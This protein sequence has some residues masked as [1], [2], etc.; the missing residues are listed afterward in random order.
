MEKVKI[1]II[2]LLSILLSACS[3]QVEGQD[4]IYN[5]EHVA[6]T[7]ESSLKESQKTE[8]EKT[9]QIEQ[10]LCEQVPE[11]NDYAD[12]ISSQ[13]DGAANLTIHIEDKLVEVY[14]DGIGSEYL[15]KYYAV[16]VGES[17]IDHSVRWDMF[18]V[19]ENCDKVLWKD[20]IRLEGSNF[21]MYTLEEWRSS[22]HYR[23]LK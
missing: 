9:D 14:K 19:S 12:Y 15:G 11:L 17:W 22:S 23:I 20:T 10:F 8:P 3:K 5:I 7:S 16:Y 2:I 4:S 21:D 13:S 6:E 18:Y 1:A